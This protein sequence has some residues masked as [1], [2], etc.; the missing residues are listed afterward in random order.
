LTFSLKTDFHIRPLILQRPNKVIGTPISAP[1]HEVRHVLQ[2]ISD[3]IEVLLLPPIFREYAAT[4]FLLLAV[5]IGPKPLYL[6]GS[7]S[8]RDR[9]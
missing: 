3:A 6:N 4:T 2:E 1:V 5:V 7:E 9:E 8:I